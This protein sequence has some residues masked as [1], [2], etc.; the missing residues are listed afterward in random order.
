MASKDNSREVFKAAKNAIEYIG[1]KKI[2]SKKQALSYEIY[3]A[4][5][6][7]DL[8][9]LLNGVRFW[10]N[11]QTVQDAENVVNGVFTSKGIAK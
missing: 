2:A 8:Y 9:E 11:A 7:G 6:Y 4:A 3:Q 10:L 1:G 5:Q